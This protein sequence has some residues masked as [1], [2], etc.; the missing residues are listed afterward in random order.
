MG[1]LDGLRKNVIDMTPEELREQIRYIRKDR[2][3]TKEKKSEKKARVKTSTAA[4]GK[5]S[6]VLKG[7]SPEQLERLL[8][9]LE[10]ENGNGST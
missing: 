4:K 7:M 9:E 1:R 6:K 8:A 5:A 10:G 3:I 2:R